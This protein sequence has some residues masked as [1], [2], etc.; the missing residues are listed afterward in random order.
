MGFSAVAAATVASAGIGAMASSSAADKAADAAK[1]GTTTKTVP[2][3]G[4][5]PY[6]LDAF[7]SAQDL[8]NTKKDTPF[9]TGNLYTGLNDTQKSGIDGIT[10]WVKDGGTSLRDAAKDG[11]LTGLGNASTF[12]NTAKD[13]AKGVY[14]TGVPGSV[15]PDLATFGNKVL[16]S[17][18]DY[19]KGLGGVLTAAGG[20]PTQANI[21]AARGYMNS[22]VLNDQI[23]AASDDV[24]HTLGTNLVGLNN[25]ASA[26]GNLNSSRAGAAEAAM[27]GEAARTIGSLSAKLRGDAYTSGL[28]LAE[29]ART[30][31]LGT[32]L[33]ALSQ[34]GS[35]FG[36]GLGALSTAEQARNAEIGN[37]LN[38][39]SQVGQSGQMGLTGAALANDMG[40]GNAN[41]VLTAG[42]V[43]QQDANN[44][45][46]ADFQKWQGNDTREND[47]L[48]QYYEIIGQNGWG[49]TKS[50]FGGYS[51]QSPSMSGVQGAIGGATTGLGLYNMYKDVTRGFGAFGSS[52]PTSYT[53][54]GMI[55]NN[56]IGGTGMLGGGI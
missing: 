45:N 3:D 41:A 18:G 4:Q 40:L 26:G 32:Q 23:Q 21:N 37:R 10:G 22:G 20:D 33:G 42:G 19:Q 15:A 17:Y 30:S 47:L 39:N 48:K 54:G 53:G 16:G 8:Y 44:K 34:Q 9:Y 56:A 12:G 35:M 27:R 46:Q 52:A 49:N 6:L 11:A 55:G 25:Q 2:W 1:Q 28:Q 43:L 5:Q 7:K 31:N 14:G 50:T 51:G 38:A 29:S 36:Q 13:F 24:T